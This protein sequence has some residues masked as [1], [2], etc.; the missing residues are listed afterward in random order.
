MEYFI[1]VF[2]FI[3]VCLFYIIFKGLFK[4]LAFGAFSGILGLIFVLIFAK[5]YLS[6]SVFSFLISLI[7]GIPGVLS[8]VFFNVFL[9]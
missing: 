3:L 4:F 8:L 9:T 2:A 6:L 5:S 7:L 1:L